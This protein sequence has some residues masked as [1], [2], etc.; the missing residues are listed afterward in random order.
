MQHK[1]KCALRDKSKAFLWNWGQVVL[2]IFTTHKIHQELEQRGFLGFAP[3]SQSFAF[4]A[5][6][7][8][9]QFVRYPD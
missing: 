5:M 7:Q 1:I 9:A 3:R 2:S 8:N 4:V 6:P